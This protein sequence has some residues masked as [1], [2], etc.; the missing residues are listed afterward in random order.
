LL[1]ALIV[2][3]VEATDMLLVSTTTQRPAG[4]ARGT[5]AQGSGLS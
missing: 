4:S 1:P 2:L 5:A 3:I